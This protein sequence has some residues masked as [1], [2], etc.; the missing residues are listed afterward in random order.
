MPIT[1]VGH[2]AGLTGNLTLTGVAAGDVCILVHTIDGLSNSRPSGTAAWPQ[3]ASGSNNFQVTAVYAHT[4]TPAEG[5]A[6]SVTDDLSWSGISAST[7]ALMFAYRGVA[8]INPAVTS[9]GGASTTITYGARSMS[10]TDGS[11]LIV[12]IGYHRAVNGA[13]QT[14]PSGLSNRIHVI[15]SVDQL[16]VHD[17]LRSAWPATDVAIGGTSSGWRSYVL[18]LIAADPPPPSNGLRRFDGAVWQPATLR[19]WNGVAWEPANLRRW[20]G[21]EWVAV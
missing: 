6:G 15:D 20:N 4:V 13:L 16:A 12:A 5:A 17:G 1:F 18:E 8:S 2:A 19:R 11:S 7:T 10:V 3:V 21:S 9:L 14:P